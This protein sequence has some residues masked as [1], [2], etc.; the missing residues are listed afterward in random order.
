[1]AMFG[2]DFGI[3]EYIFQRLNTF[4]NHLSPSTQKHLAN[5]IS[6]SVLLFSIAGP[7]MTLPQIVKIY[8]GKEAA[9][10]SAI[11]FGFYLFLAFFWLGYGVLIKNRPIVLANT[12]WILVHITIL[13]GIYLY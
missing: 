7:I 13:V 8:A 6:E 3:S 11:T 4:K 2:G 5:Y 10:L 1:M 12:F 9:G